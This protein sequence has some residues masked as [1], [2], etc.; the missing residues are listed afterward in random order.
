M[1]LA[2]LFFCAKFPKST[3][4]AEIFKPPLL[5]YSEAAAAHYPDFDIMFRAYAHLD[6]ALCVGAAC[7]RISGRYLPV[8]RK[9]GAV[10]IACNHVRCCKQR[11]YS[12]VPSSLLCACLLDEHALRAEQ[13]WLDAWQKP[14]EISNCALLLN[15]I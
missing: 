2:G 13:G 4:N 15:N 1:H 3:R 5:T 8:A 9:R 7:Q 12:R 6:L 14:V 10:R 11:A